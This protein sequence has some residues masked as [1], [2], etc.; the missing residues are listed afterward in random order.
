MHESFANDV[1]RELLPRGIDAL[2]AFDTI[3]QLRAAVDPWP[4]GGTI[5]TFSDEI[6]GTDPPKH[7]WSD[8]STARED[9]D[10]IILDHYCAP[11]SPD[12]SLRRGPISIEDS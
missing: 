11:S 8:S 1:V 6:K 2:A 10:S 7:T 9:P 12:L 4:L 3:S 5:D